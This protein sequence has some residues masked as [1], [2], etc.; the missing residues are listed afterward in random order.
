MCLHGYVQR[1]VHA[2]LIFKSDIWPAK[3]IVS[4]WASILGPVNHS[5]TFPL[6][7]H[8]WNIYYVPGAREPGRQGRR[9]RANCVVEDS[10]R[11]GMLN[12]RPSYG[13]PALIIGSGGLECWGGLVM[14]VMGTD[15]RVS[16][17]ML[18]FADA[19]VRVFETDNSSKGWAWEGEGFCFRIKYICLS[20]MRCS[21]NYFGSAWGWIGLES[22]C[23]C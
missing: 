15:L 22:S 1:L 3:R 17:W 10:V 12:R 4:M 18:V 6:K 21:R 23:S 5:F 7:K 2:H 14:S 20:G 11:F 8:L 16:V 13:R 9:W 19:C